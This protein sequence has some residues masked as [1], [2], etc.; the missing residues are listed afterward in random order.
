MQMSFTKEERE[1]MLA[2]MKQASAIFYRLA[3]HTNVHQFL[4]VNGFLCELIKVYERMHTEGKDFGTEEPT[5]KP[6]EMAYIAEKIDCIFGSALAVPR[7]QGGIPHVLGKEGRLDVVAKK[8]TPKKKCEAATIICS[9]ELIATYGVN[10]S[11]KEETTF[12]ICGPCAVY[13]RKGGAK[14]KQVA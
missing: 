14:L 1:K 9:K 11:E 10:G 8:V 2:D 4:E 12:Q 13:L 7:E 5:M 3:Q 6:Y